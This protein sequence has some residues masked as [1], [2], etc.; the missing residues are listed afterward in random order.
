MRRLLRKVPICL[1]TCIPSFHLKVCD[2]QS[3]VRRGFIVLSYIF[4]WLRIIQDQVFLL[5]IKH[6][7]HPMTTIHFIIMII[8]IIIVFILWFVLT[9]KNRQQNRLLGLPVFDFFNEAHIRTN[10]LHDKRKLQTTWGLN[11]TKAIIVE[12]LTFFQ[13]KPD[14]KNNSI[15]CD[16]IGII[17]S[18][19]KI[20]G[21]FNVVTFQFSDGHE[22][23]QFVFDVFNVFFHQFFPFW[24]GSKGRN[25]SCLVAWILKMHA[26]VD[27]FAGFAM[28]K[29]ERLKAILCF[30]Q[31]NMIVSLDASK[32]SFDAVVLFNLFWQLRTGFGRNQIIL[33]GFYH[34][35]QLINSFLHCQFVGFMCIF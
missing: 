31:V 25:F 22:I 3:N 20:I 23:F 26:F 32:E 8:I 33:I 7:K 5:G 27:L 17:N 34:C 13:Q 6:K 29:F 16:V 1:Q 10:A 12:T 4:V 2:D 21:D 11:H 19:K 35:I 9:N 30:D 15:V 18:F 28:K 14:Q 24:L